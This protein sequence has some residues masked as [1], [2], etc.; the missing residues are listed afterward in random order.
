[1]CAARSLFDLDPQAHGITS[2][3][4]SAALRPAPA[5]RLATE[6]EARAGV[7]D[8]HERRFRGPLLLVP[9]SYAPEG[10][11]RH[12]DFADAVSAQRTPSAYHV[13][14][15]RKSRAPTRERHLISTTIR[16]STSTMRIDNAIQSRGASVSI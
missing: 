7:T 3:D 14:A 2:I 4:G 16:F 9:E 13:G 1:L 10:F 15:L 12:A 8:L 5:S 6:D 11:R